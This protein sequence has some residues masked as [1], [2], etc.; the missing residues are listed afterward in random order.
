M[1]R[2]FASELEFSNVL[3]LIAAQTRSGVGRIFL[4]RLAGA[5]PGATNPRHAARLTL[6]MTELIEDGE[7]LGFAGVDDALPW[8]E[9]DA[10]PPSEPRDLLA[11][12]NLAR[13]IGAVRRTLDNAESEALHEI[14]RRLRQA[15]C[16]SRNCSP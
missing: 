15:G 11:L 14:S 8:L 3:Q 5:E 10:P 6:A 12:L 7:A 9:P 4:E 2:S 1:D 16:S 13:R